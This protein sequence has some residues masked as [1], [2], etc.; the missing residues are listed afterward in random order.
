VTAADDVEM[1][2]LA[3]L[4]GKVGGEVAGPAAPEVDREARFPVEAIDALRAVRLLSVLVPRHL[5]GAGA[6]ITQV[7]G[8]VEELGR[9]CASTSMIYAMHQIQI[10]CLVRHGRNEAL[11]RYLGEVAANELLLASATTELGVGGDVRT[12]VCAVERT[13]AGFRLQK[14]APVISYGQ[15][16]DGILATARATPDSPASDQVLVLC[17]AGDGMQLEPAGTWDTFG[18]RGT[19]SLGFLLTAEGDPTEILDDPYG[20]ISAQTMLP[21]SHVLWSSVWLGLATGAVSLARRYVRA[22]AR[23]KPGTTPPAATRLAELV[24]IHQQMSGLVHGTA[25]R[26]QDARD[27]VDQLTSMSFAIAMNSLKVSASTMVVDIVQRALTICGMAGYRED[28]PYSMGRL[29]RDAHGAALMINN[30]R[31]L[32]HNAQM[33]LVS[34]ED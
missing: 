28:S 20:D 26:Y 14:N 22:E 27:D 29:L 23:K 31:I 8:V 13:G 17:R 24:G 6:S 16:A 2:E 21:T 4:A 30:D 5:G 7:A 18:F 15:H 12:S 11:Q 19:C 25:R 1:G 32:G 9:H 3:A 34:K 10:D 33:L